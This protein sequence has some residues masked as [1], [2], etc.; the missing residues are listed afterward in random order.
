MRLEVPSDRHPSS[1]F[2][3][4][5][6]RDVTRKVVRSQLE[7]AVMLPLLAEHDRH[8]AILVMAY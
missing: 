7:R 6:L 8:A 1:A 4:G 5:T 3:V 2:A